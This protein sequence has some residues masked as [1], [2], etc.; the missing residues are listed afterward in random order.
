MSDTEEVDLGSHSRRCPVCYESLTGRITAIQPCGH[1]F[2][3]ECSQRVD[4]CPTC[5]GPIRG[6]A[7][8]FLDG[9]AAADDEE[10]TGD[11]LAGLWQR[12]RD[13]GDDATL[14]AR[15]Q[16]LWVL[17]LAPDVISRVG[18]RRC[19]MRCP[20]ARDIRRVLDVAAGAGTM[21][22]PEWETTVE[23]LHH[24]IVTAFTPRSAARRGS[25]CPRLRPVWA[26]R[27]PTGR[28]CS[29][30]SMKIRDAEGKNVRLQ[31]HA[32]RPRCAGWRRPSRTLDDQAAALAIL[33]VF[34][35][36]AVRDAGTYVALA[37]R[38]VVQARDMV[39]ALKLQAL[40]SSGFWSTPDL[41]A[42]TSRRFGEF[43]QELAAP[44]IGEEGSSSEEGDDPG[45]NSDP[46]D[47]NSDL[48]DSDEEPWCAA[49]DA[50]DP[51]AARMNRADA[52]FASWVPQNDLE[53]LV[54]EAGRHRWHLWV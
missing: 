33:S 49:P 47:D 8:V 5:R 26:V 25:T 11:T 48:G 43:R 38:R 52:D 24:S 36:N 12:L 19:E 21:T 1:L 27:R 3:N 15:A 13:V 35:D 40:P 53:A 28:G 22:Y 50:S 10:L 42:T 31:L 46:G 45:D 17:T 34:C 44:G 9:E 4:R 20:H 2:C 39:R 14:P 29:A 41:A 32:Q 23:M 37:G 54:R 7:N 18:R 6:R 30:R 16:E 51:L